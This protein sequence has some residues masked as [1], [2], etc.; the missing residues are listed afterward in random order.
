MTY[1]EVLEEMNTQIEEQLSKTLAE[2]L[3]SKKITEEAFNKAVEMLSA[4]D[5]LNEA[6]EK[7]CIPEMYSPL[8]KLKE[9]SSYSL[10]DDSP[11]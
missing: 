10:I 8:S 2:I 3:N 1:R 6:F 9:S 4:D 7:L 5:D 11:L